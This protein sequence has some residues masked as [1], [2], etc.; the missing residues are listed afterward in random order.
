MTK[1]WMCVDACTCRLCKMGSLQ[2]FTS[3]KWI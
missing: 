2:T 3:E 1:M